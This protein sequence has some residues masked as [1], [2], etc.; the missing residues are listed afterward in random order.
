MESA[1]A[2]I[3]SSLSCLW[4]RQMGGQQGTLKPLQQ[5]FSLQNKEN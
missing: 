4:G 3:Q 1:V 2:E 5:I